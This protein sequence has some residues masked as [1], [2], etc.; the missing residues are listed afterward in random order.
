MKFN[1]E[2]ST[3][4]NAPLSKVREL[5]EDFNHWNS[6]S[7]WTMLE[8]GCSVVVAGTPKELGHS[9]SWDGELIGSGKNILVAS[10]SSHLYYDL[11]FFKPWKSKAKVGFK[12]E[13]RN[14]KTD[15][16]WS[17]DSS[18]PF[19]FFFM[20]KTMKNMIGMDYERGL[21]MLK[22][23]AENGVIKCQT[24]NQGITDYT[25]FSYVGLKRTVPFSEMSTA[26][27]QDF[28]RIVNDIVVEGKKGAR[29][30][31]CLY[32]KFDTKKMIVTYIAAV[33]D[34]DAK[35]LALSSDYV[36]GV[37]ASG[38][39]L[40]VQHDG[41][42]DFLGNAWAMGM[43]NLRAKKIKAKGVPFE[44]YWNSPLE[45]SPEDLKTSVF[46]PVKA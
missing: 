5:V 41:A 34:E 14:G 1:V 24:R 11:A 4:I 26:A 25:G 23:V 21:C 2:K 8:P 10:D 37:I 30:W 33:S 19:L 42:Y 16:V 35:S 18:L 29:H 7:P 28:E 38:K 39:S 36:S 6:W 45:T 3:T 9:M 40:E 44:Q 32:P 15:V 43:I 27:A 22:E 46:F 17:M 20:V 31:V 12:I 13:E